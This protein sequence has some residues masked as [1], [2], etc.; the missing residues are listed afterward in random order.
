MLEVVQ[1]VFL[2]RQ[3]M[4]KYA[5]AGGKVDEPFP[6][7]KKLPKGEAYLET[8]A[9]KGQMGFMIISDGSPVPWRV[10]IR[11]SS[12]CNLSVTS[13][14]CRGCLLADVPAVAGS[15]DLVLGEIDR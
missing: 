6:L 14:L 10:R 8:E 5:Q 9:P 11:S 4:E 13:E 7:K 15:L 2:V 3:A 12:F 1:S